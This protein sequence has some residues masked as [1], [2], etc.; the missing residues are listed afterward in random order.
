MVH[1]YKLNSHSPKPHLLHCF[2]S[3]MFL[4]RHPSNCC[5]T[6]FFHNKYVATKLYSILRTLKTMRNDIHRPRR[7]GAGI[8][9]RPNKI[10]GPHNTVG[11]S[12][13]VTFCV[14]TYNPP[15]FPSFLE[16][17][18]ACLIGRFIAYLS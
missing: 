16:V 8:L 3:L 7:R 15:C 11:L 10:G 17:E 9:F 13:I 5:M 12:C 14:P 6:R 4:N 2:I 1:S 18:E